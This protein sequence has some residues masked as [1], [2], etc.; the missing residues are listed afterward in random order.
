MSVKLS[1]CL[2]HAWDHFSE[3]LRGRAM[4]RS[5]DIDISMFNPGGAC[6]PNVELGLSMA[7]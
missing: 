5:D 6:E 1:S 7:D 2:D 4:S 3:E